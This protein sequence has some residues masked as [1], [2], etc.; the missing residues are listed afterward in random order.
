MALLLILT[1]TATGCGTS[2][3]ETAEDVDAEVTTTEVTT[4][5]TTKA[6][7]RATTKATTVTTQSQA[8]IGWDALISVINE[9]DPN[10]EDFSAAL[11]NGNIEIQTDES[12]EYIRITYNLAAHKGKE[13]TEEVKKGVEAD[14]NAM[15]C[16]SFILNCL[17]GQS[18]STVNLYGTIIEN[19]PTYDT[20]YYNNDDYVV[21]W[22]YDDYTGHTVVFTKYDDVKKK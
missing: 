9:R 2:V 13:V 1:L 7:T 22:E 8:D 19:T 12:P 15:T 10:G 16:I 21:L 20:Q 6:T 14:V 3:T 17:F 18:S 5:V 4:K 11:D